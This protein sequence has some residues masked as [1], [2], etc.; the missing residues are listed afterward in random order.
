[1][2]SG[3]RL[4]STLRYVCAKDSYRL[5]FKMTAIL[6][7]N[8]VIVYLN[9]IL[10]YVIN[11]Y[12]IYT[13]TSICLKFFI[14]S[15]KRHYPSISGHTQECSGIITNTQE[16]AYALFQP[17]RQTRYKLWKFFI[18]IYYNNNNKNRRSR[19]QHKRKC[20]EHLQ[21]HT[22]NLFYHKLYPLSLKR[23][24]LYTNL[25]NQVFKAKLHFIYKYL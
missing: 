2:R 6:K 10:L 11:C 18:H 22:A 16:Q 24:A 20:F 21:K 19:M 9:I 14:F 8:I 25:L 7:N 13:Y 23:I 4:P 1:M 3:I 5:M 17:S 15:T 12:S